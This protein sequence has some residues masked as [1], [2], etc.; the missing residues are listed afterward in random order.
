MDLLN[1]VDAGISSSKYRGS[2]TGVYVGLTSNDYL[3]LQQDRENVIN[4]YTSTST[5][6][7]I[8]A[9]RISYLLD[10][11]GPSITIDTAC[12]SSLTAIHLAMNSLRSKETD[13]FLCGGANALISPNTFISLSQVRIKAQFVSD[14]IPFIRF[15]VPFSLFS[16]GCFKS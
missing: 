16:V 2:K 9:N 8:A 3:L 6:F 10:L 4:A 14:S 12:S 13:M 15:L 1:S 11:R 5:S 7:C